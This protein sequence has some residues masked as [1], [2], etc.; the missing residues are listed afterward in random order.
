MLSVGAGVCLLSPAM[1]RIGESVSR[2][3]SASAISIFM[4][5]APALFPE[6]AFSI[7]SSGVTRE[8]RGH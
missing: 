8:N 5:A 3:A 7:E 2:A 1:V 6:I 4:S